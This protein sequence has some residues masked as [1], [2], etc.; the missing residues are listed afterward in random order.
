MLHGFEFIIDATAISNGGSIL[1]KG[2][3][4]LRNVLIQHNFQ[5]GIPKALTL[6]HPG[7]MHIKG[8]VD[9]KY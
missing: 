7:Q 1:T 3:L 6:S 2:N 8:T 4:T 5:N 9:I